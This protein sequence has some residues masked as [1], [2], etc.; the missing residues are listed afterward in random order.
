MTTK[1]L[2]IKDAK[3][4]DIDLIIEMETHPD[5]RDFIWI[6]TYE[7]HLSEIHDNQHLLLMFYNVED[8][9]PI[10][11]SLSEVDFSSEVYELRRFAI[12]DKGKGY[13][14]EAFQAHLK[15]A[16][17]ELKVNCFWLDVFP[18]NIVGIGLYESFNMHRDGVLRQNYKTERGCLDQIV[19]SIL[20]SEYFTE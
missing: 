6:G 17:E 13:G 3:E 19:Y 16:F 4:F 18:D 8:N 20:K 9:A 7:E 5:N 12:V 14:R 15:Y 11:Y 2:V 10:G 1:R